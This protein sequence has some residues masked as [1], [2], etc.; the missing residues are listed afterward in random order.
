[1]TELA[2]AYDPKGVEERWYAFWDEKGYFRAPTGAPGRAVQHRHPAAERHRRPAHR[3]RAEQLDPGHPRSAAP[4]CRGARRCGSRAPT[5]RRSRRRTSSRRELAAEGK[6]RF[7][8]GRKGFEALFW[9]WKDEYEKRILGQLR[10]LGASCDWTHTRFT[11]DPGLSHAVRTVVRPALYDEGHIYR[12]QPDHQLVPALHVGDLGHR[13]EPRET[14][15]ARSSRC[16]IRSTDGSGAIEVATT[17]V[18]TML[19]D[20]GVAVNPNDERYKALIGK[21]VILPLVGPRDPDRRG[22]R[23]RSRRSARAR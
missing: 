2:K 17:R 3:P 9:E 14:S 6:T 20:T 1:M 15:P 8:L 22:R 23:R 7:D 21:T 11:M 10:R 12:G 19:G 4:A 18:E 16:A 5:T 13:G